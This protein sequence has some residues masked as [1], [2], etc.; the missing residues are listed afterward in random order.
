MINIYLY[1]HKVVRRCLF[2]ICFQQSSESI[3]LQ[4]L[5]GSPGVGLNPTKVTNP[6]LYFN[7]YSFMCIT[8]KP[9]Y[10]DVKMQRGNFGVLKVALR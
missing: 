1:K 4:N 8:I 10:H 3:H 9:L 7:L 6:S 2:S 5:I